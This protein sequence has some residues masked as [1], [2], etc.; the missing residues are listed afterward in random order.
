MEKKILYITPF[1]ISLPLDGGKKCILSRIKYFSERYIVDILMLNVKPSEMKLDQYNLFF[2]KVRNIMVL[3][4]KNLSLNRSGN[5]EKFKIFCNWMKSDLPRGVEYAKY[6]EKKDMIM[7][8]ILNEKINIVVFE[9]PYT[10]EVVNLKQLEKYNIKM[11]LVA[12]GV[13]SI[14]FKELRNDLPK[15]IVQMEFNRWEKYE[16]KIL[17][18]VDKVIGISPEDVKYL[19]Y[20][21]QLDNIIYIPPYFSSKKV[22]WNN[23]K[24]N[25]YIIF[26]GA[27]SFYPNYQGIKW[28]LDNVFE[29]YR[30]QYK[31]IK[32]KIT[33]KIDKWIEKEFSRYDN[34]IFTGYLSQPDLE[35]EIIYSAFTVVPILKG[36]GVKI[37]LLEALSY[38]VPT[39][40][41]LHGSEGVPFS[42]KMIPY[43]VGKDEKEM[44]EHM[45]L[46][47]E[48]D[49]QK[50]TLSANAKRFFEEIYSSKKNAQKWEQEMFD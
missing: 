20:H 45:I 30:L 10:T 29:K 12:H 31:N 46:L 47:T 1:A 33:G 43:L 44:L 34:L 11:I 37:K 50:E 15:I 21:H 2:D 36:S 7:Q 25:D 49:N 35:K 39:I 22:V 13:E 6:D 26:C 14:F 27:L 9:F 17:K 28:F 8:Y 32:L 48:D 41:T 38:G 19:Q 3:P 5:W 24:K 16:N 18:Q 4:D 23:T 40:T 42:Q